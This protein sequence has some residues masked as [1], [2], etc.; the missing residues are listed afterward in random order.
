MISVFAAIAEGWHHLA[1]LGHS[2]HAPLDA[3]PVSGLVALPPPEASPAAT[4]TGSA[5]GVPGIDLSGGGVAPPGSEKITLILRW[6]FWG[7]SGLCV[8]GVLLVAGKMAIIHGRGEGGEHAR[9]LGLVAL[10]A[11][12]AASAT[13]L[14]GA[15]L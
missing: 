15:L 11:V 14:I 6:V 12:L 9:G 8:A 1:V 7:V 2:A 5:G 4:A 3:L 13:G 10:A